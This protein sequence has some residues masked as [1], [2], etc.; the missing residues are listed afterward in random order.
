MTDSK[1]AYHHD[2]REKMKDNKIRERRDESVHRIL[3][4]AM[5]TFAEV[6]YEGARVD[7]IAKRAGVNKAMIYY[8]IGDKRTLYEEVLHDVFGNTIERISENIQDDL[9]PEEK[10]KI[11]IA[12]LAKTME[13]HPCFPRIMMREVASGW[14]HFS[15]AVVKDIAGILVIIRT[16]I[17]EGVKEGVFI[18][19]NPVIV[20]L[21][22]IG[23]MLLFNLSVP[24]RKNFYHLLEGN[25]NI[26]EDVSFEHIV[27]EIQR[28]MLRVVKA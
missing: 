15:E 16:I 20:H 11:Y 19:I 24:V 14:T 4:A 21:M 5:E 9:S 28:M 26:P 6:G 25:I 7:E 17:D 2:G 23:T 12:N 1:V 22:T 18:D 13:Q 10:F 8:R 3:E 27:P